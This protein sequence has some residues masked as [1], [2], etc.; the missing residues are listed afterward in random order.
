MNWCQIKPFWKTNSHGEHFS[1]TYFP[2]DLSVIKTA[3]IFYRKCCTSKGDHTSLHLVLKSR[4]LQESV[5]ATKLFFLYKLALEI[6]FRQKIPFF[7]GKLKPPILYLL[8][9]LPL[10]SMKMIIRC[11]PAERLAK[12]RDNCNFWAKKCITSKSYVSP[13]LIVQQTDRKEFE[14]GEWH[15]MGTKF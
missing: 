9:L 6:Y 11:R 7:E 2:Q 1:L 14:G 10:I 12:S 3:T 8:L 13:Y 5:L 15:V 4:A